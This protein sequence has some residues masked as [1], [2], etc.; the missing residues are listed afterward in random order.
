MFEYGN[1]GL[2]L[3]EEIH[4]LFVSQ[5]VVLFSSH[6]TV[7]WYGH[8]VNSGNGNNNANEQVDKMR[9]AEKFVRE[10]V[11]SD[12]SRVLLSFPLAHASTNRT[13]L[14]PMFAIESI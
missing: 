3:Y 12:F 8:R 13:K 9:P 10:S 5:V 2:Y 1:G 7:R 11:F 6:S 4:L 14:Y